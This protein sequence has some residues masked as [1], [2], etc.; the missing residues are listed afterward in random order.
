MSDAIAR[1][2]LGTWTRRH[3]LRRELHCAML[4]PDDR[5][6]ALLATRERRAGRLRDDDVAV[7]RVELGP[8]DR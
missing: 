3:A 1:W 7:L 2:Y 4:A 6:L 5:A 8:S